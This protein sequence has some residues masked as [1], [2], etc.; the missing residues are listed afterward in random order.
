[1]TLD[2]DFG[3]D[4]SASAFIETA[5]KLS[6]RLRNDSHAPCADERV[7]VHDGKWP[8]A[9]L[10]DQNHG[11]GSTNVML[12]QH[13]SWRPSLQI[14]VYGNGSSPNAMDLGTDTVAGSADLLDTVLARMTGRIDRKEHHDLLQ[15]AA[16]ICG[17]LTGPIA[18]TIIL[19]APSPWSTYRLTRADGLPIEVPDEARPLLDTLPAMTTVDVWIQS[20]R[21]DVPAHPRGAIRIR[22][23]VARTIDPISVARVLLEHPTNID[24]AGK[25]R[26][27]A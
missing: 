2:E 27:W 21:E 6:A 26:T 12:H 25:A 9:V 11:N 16:D 15:T 14:T 22:S 10:T 18:S 23:V 19:H 7:R 1:M 5:R 4:E 13:V 24:N 3:T 20:D 8:L 17:A